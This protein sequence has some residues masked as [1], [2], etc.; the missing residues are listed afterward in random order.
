M[1][2][3]RL[4]KRAIAREV[5]RLL[6]LPSTLS[7]VGEVAPVFRS[8]WKAFLRESVATGLRPPSGAGFHG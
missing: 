7:V 8:R 4:L 6:R 1:E 5:F 2:I 3:L